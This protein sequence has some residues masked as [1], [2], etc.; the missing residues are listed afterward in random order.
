MA[1]RKKRAV[2]KPKEEKKK[3]TPRVKE[4]KKPVKKYFIP[5]K[6]EFTK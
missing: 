1:R 3:T 2:K 6:G 4:T 5:G